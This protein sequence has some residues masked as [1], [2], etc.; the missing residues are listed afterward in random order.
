MGTVQGN[1]ILHALKN[2]AAIKS[3]LLSDLSEAEL[4]IDGI[5]PDMI[6]DLTTNVLRGKLINY[7]QEQC[8]LY[9]IKALTQYAGPPIWNEQTKRWEA[10]YCDIPFINGAPVILV[11]K[12]SVRRR[13]SLDSQEFYNFHMIEYL[14]AEHI[15]ANS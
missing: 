9:G 12:Y 3:G 15:R 8:E 6:S 10:K 5:G 4:F 1:R 7:T 13:I 14:R 11:P 2:S